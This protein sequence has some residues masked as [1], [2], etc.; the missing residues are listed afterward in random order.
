MR[1]ENVNNGHKNILLFFVSRLSSYKSW[2]MQKTKP[3][4]NKFYS[5]KFVIIKL[6]LIFFFLQRFIGTRAQ[7]EIDALVSAKTG[8]CTPLLIACRNGHYD[9]VQYLIKRCHT[10]KTFYFEKKIKNILL[11]KC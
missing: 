10:G 11:S 7:N 9:I 2:A 6:T 1:L 5:I 8:G 3:N 4:K